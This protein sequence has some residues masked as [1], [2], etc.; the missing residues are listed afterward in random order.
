MS[1]MTQTKHAL[2]VCLE[3]EQLR[4]SEQQIEAEKLLLISSKLFC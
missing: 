1:V 3:N 2:K 4:G